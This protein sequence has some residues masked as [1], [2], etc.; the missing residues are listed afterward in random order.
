MPTSEFIAGLIGPTLVAISLAILTNR[1][2]LEAM[3]GQV[4]DNYTVVF[5]AGVIL[6]VCGLAIVRVHNIWDP[7]WPILI[8]AFGWLAVFGGI[9]RMM[10]PD[11]SATLAQ[12]FVDNRIAVNTTAILT[13][14]IGAYIT[15]KGYS[16]F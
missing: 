8:T 13:L 12:R 1:T 16:L 3:I 7:G 14:L 4:A 5:L 6:L 9:V 11:Q 2:A 10:I 15:G